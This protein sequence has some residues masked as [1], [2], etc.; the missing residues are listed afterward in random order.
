MTIPAAVTSS[1]GLLA[2]ALVPYF[3]LAIWTISS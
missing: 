3:L 1:I 2:D